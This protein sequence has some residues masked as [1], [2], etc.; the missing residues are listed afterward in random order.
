MVSVGLKGA[1]KQ[2]DRSAEV[3]ICFVFCGTETR[4]RGVISICVTRHGELIRAKHQEIEWCMVAVAAAQLCLA[5]I[6]I[7]HNIHSL[8]EQSQPLLESLHSDTCI[9]FVLLHAP[10]RLNNYNINT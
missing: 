1:T 6:I 7:T 10:H 4:R 9:G 2:D 3:K 8:R 5:S